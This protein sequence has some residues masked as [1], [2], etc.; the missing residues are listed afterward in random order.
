MKWPQVVAE[1]PV[2]LLPPKTACGWSF[3]RTPRV[4]SHCPRYVGNFFGLP[5][6]TDKSCPSSSW[7]SFVES[8]SLSS[9]PGSKLCHLLQVQEVTAHGNFVYQSL[10]CKSDQAVSSPAF[11]T[12]PGSAPM[13]EQPGGNSRAVQ[14]ISFLF[15]PPLRHPV[16]I[17]LSQI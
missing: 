9:V 11:P 5:C 2:Y 12:A 13:S 1:L 3:S 17:A 16:Y 14:R 15:S 7:L 4:S 6:E 8:L 10:W